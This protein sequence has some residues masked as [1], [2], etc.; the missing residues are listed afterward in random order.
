[1]VLDSCCSN[2]HRL[3]TYRFVSH[4]WH[5]KGTTFFAMFQIF[6]SDLGRFW[7]RIHRNCSRSAKLMRG[8]ALLS[9]NHNFQHQF[10]RFWR[11]VISWSRCRN[12]RGS[13]ITFRCQRS[14]WR[15][16][17][18]NFVTCEFVTLSIFH[19]IIDKTPLLYYKLYNIIILYNSDN[20]QPIYRNSLMSQ[21]QMSQSSD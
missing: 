19:I 2:L 12:F 13:G 8:M 4:D 15:F 6:A 1:M 3:A 17:L 20:L 10:A 11:A 18:C 16:K 21:S 9:L 5:C 14:T 7:W